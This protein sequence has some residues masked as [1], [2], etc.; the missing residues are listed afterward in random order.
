MLR[1]QARLYEYIILQFI[2]ISILILLHYCRRREYLHKRSNELRQNTLNEK[3]NK[4][5][6]N[7]SNVKTIHGTIQSEAFSLENKLKFNIEGN[8]LFLFFKREIYVL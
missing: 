6:E 5:E 8:F 2:D 3:K 4:I 7:I 1:K